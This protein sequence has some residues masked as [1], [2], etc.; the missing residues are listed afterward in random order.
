MRECQARTKEKVRW[1]NERKKRER[2]RG[3]KECLECKR[4]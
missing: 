2:E 4:L 1:E 3:R